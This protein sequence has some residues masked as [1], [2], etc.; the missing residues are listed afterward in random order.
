[1]EIPGII[2]LDHYLPDMN[3]SEVCSRLKVHAATA[4]I[5]VLHLSHHPVE[6]SGFDTL[7]LPCFN[8]HF[9]E[10]RMLRGEGVHGEHQAKLHP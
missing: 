10:R 3:G 6:S 1:M 7:I 8:G 5:P 9:S 4:V 2:V